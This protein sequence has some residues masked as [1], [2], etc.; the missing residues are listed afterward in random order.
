MV[1]S[2]HSRYF[3]CPAGQF[4][5]PCTLLSLYGSSKIHPHDLQ[6]HR[7]VGDLRQ[8]PVYGPDRGII[9]FL[10]AQHVAPAGNGKARRPCFQLCLCILY[11]ALRANILDARLPCGFKQG[12]A[13]ITFGRLYNH[14]FMPRFLLNGEYFHRRSNS[15]KVIPICVSFN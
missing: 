2:F 14:R 1:Y 7:P 3:I 10:I 15:P 9:Q 6:A 13:R 8:Q 11:G 5:R 12:T 4:H